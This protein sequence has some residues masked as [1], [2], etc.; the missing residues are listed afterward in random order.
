M[1]LIHQKLRSEHSQK[2][3]NLYCQIYLEQDEQ[4]DLSRH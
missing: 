4:E 2:E 3:I 1:N